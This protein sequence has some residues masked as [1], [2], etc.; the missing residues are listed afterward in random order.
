[1][2]K[3][4]LSA[5]FVALNPSPK[6]S[7]CVVTYNQRDFIAQCLQSLVDQQVD[8]AFEV[9]VGDDCSTDGTAE[10]V[11]SF[12][13]KYPRIIFPVLREKNL[14]GAGNYLDVH[15][16]AR[17]MY[18]AHVDG[19]DYA[20][21]GKLRAQSVFL[22]E[23]PSCQIAWHRMKILDVGTG[24]VYDQYY[25]GRRLADLRFGVDDLVRSIT[26]GLHSSKMYR[27]W[28][29]PAY[30]VSDVLDFTENVCH[31]DFSGGYAGFLEDG[32]YG[33][34][35]INNGISRNR[36]RMRVK[37]YEWLMRFHGQRIG[38][39]KVLAAKIFVMVLS[40]LKHRSPSLGFGLGV[41]VKVV[42]DLSLREILICRRTRLPIS[43]A[44]NNSVGMM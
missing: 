9:I 37:I 26:L 22:D 5:E 23:N 2:T 30:D 1:M 38:S 33:V 29:R 40:D 18:I 6:V 42:A 35:R 43:L 41:L 27:R 20:L 28:D 10:V 39:R 44:G 11:A 8:F 14:G 16:L 36:G 32:V 31:L 4:V 15:S 25:D 24:D 13:A 12:A 3:T 34:Y 21:P 7:V 17:G 19:D